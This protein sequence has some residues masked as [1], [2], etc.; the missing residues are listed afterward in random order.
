M[1]APFLAA[2][3]L[4]PVQA[5]PAPAPAPAQATPEEAR[6][7]ARASRLG[8]LLYAYD[9][10]AWKAT[11]AM[12]AASGRA[13]LP[14]DGG[15]VIEAEP[16]RTL[17]VTFYAGRPDAA[18]VL[19]T[20]RTRDGEVIE[21][22][23]VTTPTPLTDAQ[24]RLAR[25]RDAA[26]AEAVARGWRPCTPAPFNAV[27]LPAGEADG[28][29]AVYLLSPQVK[30]GAYPLGGHHRVLIGPDGEV[31]GARSFT[32]GC[33]TMEP[34]KPPPGGRAVGLFVNH[35]LDP[36][37]TEM[38]V[39]S[40]YAARMPIMVGTRDKRLWQVMGAKITPGSLTR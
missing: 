25:A 20:A 40:S 24:K 30:A 8:A 3:L 7:I 38:H 11:D 9:R 17:V 4:A 26:A 2:L 12:V 16:N 15:W 10:A 29:I 39:F 6:A 36:V 27:M 33:L 32:S 31:A 34:P 1:I 23:P 22:R 13:G 35:L 18:R 14:R 21:G 28:P 37:P 5:Q 19:F